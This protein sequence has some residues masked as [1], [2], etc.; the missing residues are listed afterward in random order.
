MRSTY[1]QPLG[2]GALGPRRSGRQGAQGRGLPLGMGPESKVRRR[3]LE[4]AAGG[5]AGA[6]VGRH[7]NTTVGGRVLGCS[8]EARV[9]DGHMWGRGGG[10]R[11][12]RPLQGW[13]A[14]PDA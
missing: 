4:G 3:A 5:S 8:G 2:A 9:W 1:E 10:G 6:A 11:A 12:S 13:L 7:N 14:V